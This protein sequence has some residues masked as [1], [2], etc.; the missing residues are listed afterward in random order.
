[1]AL[2]YFSDENNMNHNIIISLL[3][4]A[5]IISGVVARRMEMFIGENIN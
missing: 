3:Q 5:D 1:M 4:K 2:N